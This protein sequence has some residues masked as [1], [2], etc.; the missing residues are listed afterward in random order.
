M[1]LNL[2]EG[3]ETSF[4]FSGE[5]DG[6]MHTYKAYY[7]TAKQLRPIQVGYSRMKEI[8]KEYAKLSE[9]DKAQK[10]KLE[11]ELKKITQ[12]MTETFNNMFEPVGDSMPLEEF[13]DNLPVPAKKN[14]DN[15]ISK[16]LLG[17]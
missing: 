8:D 13:I 7:P 6:K 14:F 3:L 5:I 12:E 10:L 2:T 11:K 9:D 15:M 17:A 1:S 16:E 4:T